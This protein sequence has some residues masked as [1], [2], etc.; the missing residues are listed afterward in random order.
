MKVKKLIV[1]GSFGGQDKPDDLVKLN[2]RVPEL[3]IELMK[4]HDELVEAIRA[5]KELFKTNEVYAELLGSIWKDLNN[6]TELI[7]HHNYRKL[8]ELCS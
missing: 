4:T 7:S 1:P 8:E 5:N 3:E 6:G 2:Q